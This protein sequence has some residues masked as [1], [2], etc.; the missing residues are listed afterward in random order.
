M[1]GVVLKLVP[2]T[3]RFDAKCDEILQDAID[4]GMQDVIVVGYTKSGEFYAA[5]N[6]ADG[7]EVVYLLELLKHKLL[8]GDFCERPSSA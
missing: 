1:S 3:S 8:S 2:P 4:R 7:A 6:T 5:S